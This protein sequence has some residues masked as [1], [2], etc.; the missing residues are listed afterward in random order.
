MI[1]RYSAPLCAVILGAVCAVLE[2]LSRT[3]TLSLALLGGA[4]AV[5]LLALAAL[6]R[7]Y[8]IHEKWRFEDYFAGNDSILKLFSVLGGLLLALGGAGT[9]VGAVLDSMTARSDPL[10]QALGGFSPLSVLPYIALALLAVAA[11]YSC[12]ALAR[13]QARGEMTEKTAGLTL[14]PLIWAVLDLIIVFKNNNT[15]PYTRYYLADL[16]CGAALTLAFLFYCRFL[17]GKIMPR[18]FLFLAGA[19]VVLSLTAAGGG[20]LSVLLPGGWNMLSATDLM[21]LISALGAAV[22]LLGQMVRMCAPRKQVYYWQD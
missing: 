17:Y 5:S 14:F 12:V 19:G 3:R 15:N 10:E 22:Y 7:T 2:W 4:L 20:A 11:A 21:R 9:L 13:A 6:A 8:E 16:L 1:R 18:R